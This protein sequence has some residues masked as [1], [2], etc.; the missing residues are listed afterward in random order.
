[1][2]D[3]IDEVQKEFLDLAEMVSY[4]LN[5]CISFRLGFVREMGAAVFVIDGSIRG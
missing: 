1:M 2:S 3:A 5:I 4:R